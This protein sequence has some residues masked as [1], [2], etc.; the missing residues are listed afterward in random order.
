MNRKVRD[1]L[2]VAAWGLI[3]LMM[4]CAI[5]HRSQ[6]Q[7]GKTSIPLE[8]IGDIQHPS[9]VWKLPRAD[10]EDWFRFVGAINQENRRQYIA[11]RDQLVQYGGAYL[12]YHPPED[13][14]LYTMERPYA[15]TNYSVML[16]PRGQAGANNLYTINRTNWS[17]QFVGVTGPPDSVLI[18]IV[19]MGRRP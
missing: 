17:F 13:T 2:G 15:D 12:R 7:T 16:C 18:D 8:P 10:R 5:G 11:I 14:V 6:S 1:S 19:T 3:I 9:F 4:I